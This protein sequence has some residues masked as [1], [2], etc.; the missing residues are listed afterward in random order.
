MCREGLKWNDPDTYAF[1]NT[2]VLTKINTH[3]YNTTGLL[4]VCIEPE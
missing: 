2:Y 1:T 4:C 3:V